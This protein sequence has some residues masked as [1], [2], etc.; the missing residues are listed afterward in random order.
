[1][2]KE[3]CLREQSQDPQSGAKIHE[4]QLPGSRNES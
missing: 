3:E 2:E 1:M 4:E